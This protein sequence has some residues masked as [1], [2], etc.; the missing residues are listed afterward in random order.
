MWCLS[1]KF[2]VHSCIRRRT[3]DWVLGFGAL[4]VV[5]HAAHTSLPQFLES[6]LAF[7]MDVL[8]AA[9][10]AYGADR[11]LFTSDI[12]V[13]RRLN[14]VTESLVITNGKD[15]MTRPW[16]FPIPKCP[17]GC[18]DLPSGFYCQKKRNTSR[19]PTSARR[20]RLRCNGCMWR[21]PW[22]SS[23]VDYRLYGHDKE[24]LWIAP[25]PRESPWKSVQWKAPE[26]DS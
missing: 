11:F 23:P 5:P 9:A 17:N 14:G 2:D 3:F 6:V 8:D 22:I 25:F 19:I 10:E 12:V 7:R 18:E 20:I 1:S 16:G 21:T 24:D 4:G 13:L 15:T 26:N